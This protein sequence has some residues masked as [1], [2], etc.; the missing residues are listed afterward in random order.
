MNFKVKIF[1]HFKD[2]ERFIVFLK[3]YMCNN[4]KNSHVKHFHVKMYHCKLTK[5]TKKFKT[6]YTY[7]LTFDRMLGQKFALV[8][9]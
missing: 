9:L 4:W 1:I 6:N 7:G 3:N 2:I 5:P 8:M